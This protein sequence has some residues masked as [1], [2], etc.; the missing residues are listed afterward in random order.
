MF[1]LFLAVITASLLMQASGVFAQEESGR[2][3]EARGLFEAGRAAFDQG[4]Y[5]DA[6]GYFDRSYQLSR[7]PQLLYNIGQVHDRLRHD[8]EAL[9]ALTQY[10]KQVPGATNREEVEH[11]IEALKHAMIGTLHFT[12]T[13]AAAQV[14]IDGEAKTLDASGRLQVSTGSH[15]ILVRAE[16]Y[17]E[18]RQRMNVRGGDVIEL[19]IALQSMDPNAPAPATIVTGPT[20]PATTAPTAPAQPA[21]VATTTAPTVAPTPAVEAP[22]P[23]PQLAYATLPPLPPNRTSVATTFGWVAAIT[24]G[25]L[26]IGGTVT[27]IVG[28]AEFDSLEED[29]SMRCTREDIND[30]SDDIKLWETLTNVGFI[31]GGVLA[32]VATGLFVIGAVS[33]DT[34]SAQ[35][36]VAIGPGSLTVLGRF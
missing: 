6:L 7:R 33:G 21:P 31:G 25:V 22:A 15:E 14:W 35:P 12:I 26:L 4:R 20:T 16:G 13:P 2:D 30:S 28:S 32:G 29:C 18:L 36:T 23:Q 24:S 8:D 27:A 9:Q 1:R 3:A 19:P 11:R 5:Q 10:L 17:E 34:E